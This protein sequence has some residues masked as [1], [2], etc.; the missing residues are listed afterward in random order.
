MKT[1]ED[2]NYLVTKIKININK[3]ISKSSISDYLILIALGMTLKYGFDKIDSVCNV[4]TNVDYIVNADV[5]EKIIFNNGISIK[6]NVVSIKENNNSERNAL[7]LQAKSLNV[8]SLKMLEILTYEINNLFNNQK[9]QIN[10]LY[11]TSIDGLFSNYAECID[12]NKIICNSIKALQAEDI[13]KI[14]LNLK[15]CNILDKQVKLFVD[16]ISLI[17]SD[18][19]V[20]FNNNVTLNIFRRLYEI[21]DFKEK[22]NHL[23][24]EENIINLKTDLKEVIGMGTY[25]ELME[26]IYLLNKSFYQ[27]N[28]LGNHYQLSQIYCDIRS[29]IMKYIS[30]RY[31]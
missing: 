26:K 24:M 28:S 22:I 29:I 2:I 25:E 21:D 31:A 5:L 15:N 8:P 17:D 27:N 3:G 14:I 4:I 11:E 16:S 7:V 13:I 12:S 23:S 30:I 1:T 6:S 18:N 10:S 20:Y 9:K 19:Y